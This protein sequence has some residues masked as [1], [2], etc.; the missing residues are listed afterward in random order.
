[1]VPWDS[2]A[3]I[4]VNWLQGWYE[5]IKWFRELTNSEDGP[6]TTAEAR[7]LAEVLEKEGEEATLV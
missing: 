7:K 5:V 2:E 1:M 4:S 3:Q 6:G